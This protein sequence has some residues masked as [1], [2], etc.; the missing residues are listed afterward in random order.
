[1]HKEPAIII[2]TPQSWDIEIDST[3]K[4]LAMEFARTRPVI[5]L[6][7]PL[8]HMTRLR[9]PSS[10][11]FEHKLSVLM[12]QQTELRVVHDQLMVLDFPFMLFSINK[13]PFVWLFN[14]F[15]YLN[16][17][18]I[19]RYLKI[20]LRSLGF[21]EII[22]FADTDIYRSFYLK[23]LLKPK[24]SV[25]YKRDQFVG[26]DFWKPHGV[27]L[28]PLLMK[29][30]DLVIVNSSFFAQEAKRFNPNCFDVETGVNLQQFNAEIIPP[31]P[32]DMQQIPHPRIGYFGVIFT[33][34]LDIDLI[35]FITRERPDCQFVMVG[36]EDD[37]FASH[38]MHQR[39]N[40]WFL[41]KK[42]PAEIPAYTQY[43]DVCFN[44]Q[45]VNNITD[46][47]YPLKVDQYLALGKPVVATSTHTMKHIFASTCYLA[48]SQEAFASQIDR[49]IEEMSDNA[50]REA[51]LALARSHSW[52]NIAGKIL[53]IMNEYVS[54]Q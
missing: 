34:R 3:I 17:W 42:T 33:L 39:K 20:K 43:F 18:R 10:K 51:R 49:A 45:V 54:P 52:D 23:D 16:N 53:K 11:S 2:S 35:D 36:P 50:K 4:N 38:P 13:L 22:L 30:S 28:E 8:D 12:G 29:K 32:E 1:M 40:V 37:A 7:S 46:G 19:A 44:P 5:Y 48:S 47:N 9:R 21:D 25:Y 6:N 14:F 26:V 27:R 41:G 15:N 31:E 24:L